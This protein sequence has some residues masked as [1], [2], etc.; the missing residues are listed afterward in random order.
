MWQCPAGIKEGGILWSS[1]L[2]RFENGKYHLKAR[3]V[4]LSDIRQGKKSLPKHNYSKLF[5]Y[6]LRIASHLRVLHA[7][8]LPASPHCPFSAFPT[9]AAKLQEQSVPQVSVGE[10]RQTSCSK[11]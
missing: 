3:E 4:P 11:A 5:T 8:A 7:Q 9:F 1:R 6:K 2:E 10:T